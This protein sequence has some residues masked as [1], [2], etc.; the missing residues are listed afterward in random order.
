MQLR[1]CLLC[2]HAVWLKFVEGS[3]LE[4]WKGLWNVTLPQLVAQPWS[5]QEF[6][7]CCCKQC[8]FGERETDYGMSTEIQNVPEG[9]SW[10]SMPRPYASLDYRSD[11]VV[12][13]E[14]R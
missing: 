10:I 4:A 6:C 11:E 7:G 5:T 1:A 13:T 8:G 9:I 12:E 2:D 3:T 14:V